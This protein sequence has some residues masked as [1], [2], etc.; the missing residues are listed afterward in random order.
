VFW[1]GPIHE[2]STETA[3]GQVG[4]LACVETDCGAPDER[5][6]DGPGDAQYERRF[7]GPGERAL[8]KALRRAWRPVLRKEVRRAGGRALREVGGPCA[9][10]GCRLLPAVAG[11]GFPAGRQRQ[12]G[13][14]RRRRAPCRRIGR[15][16]TADC[17]EV[18][19]ARTDSPADVRADG[20]RRSAACGLAQEGG[21]REQAADDRR[22][23][24]VAR[25]P[26]GQG[27]ALAGDRRP[28][29]CRRRFA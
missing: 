14:K 3:V 12:A 29:E 21:C 9:G 11:C 10:L 26:S 17:G 2:P 15:L 20:R 19:T 13:R 24:K 5:C 25:R 7:D 16:P 28:G 8:R 22:A 18:R 4:G 23:T 6:C 27:P 1:R